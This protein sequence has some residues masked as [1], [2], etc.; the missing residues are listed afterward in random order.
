MIFCNIHSK[1]K[2]RY[3]YQQ[4]P[5][6]GVEPKK[7]LDQRLRRRGAQTEMI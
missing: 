2:H 1:E 7:R 4:I 5:Y 3:L 6:S